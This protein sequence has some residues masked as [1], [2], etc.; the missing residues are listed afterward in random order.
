M[1]LTQLVNIK[2]IVSSQYLSFLVITVV[3][4]MQPK[5]R[6]GMA[7][8]FAKLVSLWAG[9][10]LL[11]LFFFYIWAPHSPLFLIQINLR[12]S[13]K[14]KVFVNNV[15]DFQISETHSSYTKLLAASLCH[16]EIIF[17]P[18]QLSLKL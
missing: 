17:I 10:N 9:S 1:K 13:R 3:Y 16:I 8:E 2:M 6:E 11:N 4:F 12:L 7:R 14:L 18:L 5:N 15:G